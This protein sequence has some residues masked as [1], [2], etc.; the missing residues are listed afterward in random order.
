MIFL[1]SASWVQK[2]Q[3][4]ATT[5]N[6]LFHMPSMRATRMTQW[7][8]VL[9]ALPEDA[10]TVPS[11]HASGSP[12]PGSGN[13][14]KYAFF[15]SDWEIETQ[16]LKI[17]PL[18]AG[19]IAPLIKYL[20]CMQKT[21]VCSPRVDWPGTHSEAKNDL[22]LWVFWSASP[23]CWDYR[24]ALTNPGLCSAGDWRAS[25]PYL[26]LLISY[27]LFSRLN[28]LSASGALC[29]S[30]LGV[31]AP[32]GSMRSLSE[33]ISGENF[34]SLSVIIHQLLLRRGPSWFMF[35]Y[36]ACVWGGCVFTMWRSED[37]L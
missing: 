31:G 17:C 2:L 10:S 32:G 22:E 27:I 16:I 12:Q 37:S 19:E 36:W 25:H 35:V 13:T 23:K 15:F 3:A 20:L 21:W 9:A 26:P 18:E 14:A 28:T 6:L 1:A 30:V 24:C 7:W 5:W 8:R 4:R 33:A 29:Q 11:I 34:L